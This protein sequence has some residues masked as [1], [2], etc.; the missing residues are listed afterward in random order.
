[1]SIVTCFYIALRKSHD[2]A[3]SHYWVLL[4]FSVFLIL[5]IVLAINTYSRCAYVI[6][7]DIEKYKS[8]KKNPKQTEIFI[9]FNKT[10]HIY[11]DHQ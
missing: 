1:M 6:I 2:T 3:F 11:T 10:T 8:K 9:F 4:K 7:K 5:N